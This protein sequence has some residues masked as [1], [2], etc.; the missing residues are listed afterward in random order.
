[1]TRGWPP[2]P[3][4]GRRAAAVTA[5]TRRRPSARRAP[6]GRRAPR[7]HPRRPVRA[8]LAERRRD[9]HRL[10]VG[11]LHLLGEVD[12]ELAILRVVGPLARRD[13]IDDE[14]LGHAA[15]ELRRRRRDQRV[16]PGLAASRPIGVEV[17]D[18]D[19]LEIARA[20]H[21]RLAVIGAGGH[22]VRRP[23]V[24]RGEVERAQALIEAGR[25]TRKIAHPQHQRRR[26]MMAS[27]QGSPSPPATS[28][29]P[30]AAQVKRTE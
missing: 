4:R 26:R 21:Q 12:H 13:L 9:H 15:V 2:R 17:V 16:R 24:E 29:A 28:A 5:P 22:E 6:G 20:P 27:T 30:T 10:A 25:A 3:R 7:I 18:V 1:M 19:R 11:V 23:D 14:P 8:R